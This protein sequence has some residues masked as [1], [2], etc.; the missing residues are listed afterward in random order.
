M[1]LLTFA[2]CC[3]ARAKYGPVGMTHFGYLLRSHQLGIYLEKL[4]YLSTEPDSSFRLRLSMARAAMAP[5][6]AHET[7][8]TNATSPIFNGATRLTMTQFNVMN[9]YTDFGGYLLCPS[10]TTISYGNLTRKIVWPTLERAT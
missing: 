3:V 7:S 9:R 8:D 10:N 4:W 5:S 1:D 2:V 6:I